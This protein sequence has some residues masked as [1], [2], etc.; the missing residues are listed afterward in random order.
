MGKLR[1]R[2]PWVSL[3]ELGC[4]VSAGA[5]HAEAACARFFGFRPLREVRLCLSAAL[6]VRA[7]CTWIERALL[8]TSSGSMWDCPLGPCIPSLRVGAASGRLSGLWSR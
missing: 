8:L 3:F 4:H 6:L 1:N 7:P 2:T 5:V